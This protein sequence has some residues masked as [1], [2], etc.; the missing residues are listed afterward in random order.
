MTDDELAGAWQVYHGGDAAA[1]REACDRLLAAD[2]DNVAALFLTSLIDHEQGDH[3]AAI[4]RLRRVLQLRPRYAEAHNN[5]GNALAAAGQLAQAESSFRQA[6]RCKPQYAE[7]LNNLGNALRDQGKLDD[8]I[9]AFQRAWQLRPDYAEC[10]N[11]LGIALARQ[12]KF[13]EAIQSYRRALALKPTFAEPQNNLG[14][15]L[16]ASGQA[17]K[18]VEAFRWAIDLKPGYVDALANLALTLVDLGRLDEAIAAYRRAVALAPRAARLHNGLGIALAKRGE[19]DGEKEGERDTENDS[20][21]PSGPLSVSPSLPLSFLNEAIAAF[22]SAIEVDPNFAEA[23]NNL[24]NALRELGRLAEAEEHLR[25]A[26]TLKADY[27]EAHNNLGVVLVKARRLPEALAAYERAL[28]HKRDYAEAHL[29]RALAW[30]AIGDFRRGWVEYEWRWRAPGFQELRCPQPRWDGGLLDGKT[31]LLWAEQGLGDT[32]QFVRYAALLRQRGARVVLRA[33]RALHPLL[34][35]TPGIDQLFGEE[36]ELPRCHCHA[37]LLSL[38]RLFATTLDDIPSDVP[39]LFPDE[40]LV[41]HWRSRIRESSG[42]GSAGVGEEESGRGEEKERGRGGDTERGRHGERDSAPG[43]ENP[44]S[45]IQNPKSVLI[46]IAW[47]GN[48]HYR[49]DRQR[50][51]PLRHFAALAA[52]P[53]VRLISLQKGQ[54]AEQLGGQWSVASGQLSEGEAHN[55]K[56]EI[57]NPKSNVMD[58]GVIDEESGAFTDTAALMANLDLVITSDTAIAHLAGG[59]GV[60]VAV[61]LPHAGIAVACWPI[62]RIDAGPDD[63]PLIEE[64][65]EYCT[66]ANALLIDIDSLED[67]RDDRWFFGQGQW[68]ALGEKQLEQA[69]AFMRRVHAQKQGGRCML[70]RPGIETARRFTWEESASRLLSAL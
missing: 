21:A 68:A 17:E 66:P 39:Y 3:R 43:T 7:A 69:V 42:A 12:K 19:R 67:A 52:I 25:Q 46:G 59:M 65:T 54:G 16:A 24:G 47:Q 40:R 41:A 50:S 49:G 58:L 5:L 11:N 33:P 34:S 51:I 13:G 35:R 26:L 6:L 2:A 57:Q 28:R 45:K 15:V 64:A 55:P 48:P 27:A 56:S 32:F 61:L 23:H 8:A 30:L 9:D 60:P 62:G 37:P 1:A 63:Q 70:N 4:D 22:R 18:A 36:Q 29:N 53:G 20:L 14:I 10:H 31:I 44:K 38:P